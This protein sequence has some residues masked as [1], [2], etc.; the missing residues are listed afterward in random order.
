MFAATFLNIIC[1]LIANLRMDLQVAVVITEFSTSINLC[2]EDFHSQVFKF[3]DFFTMTK[4][5]NLSTSI[6]A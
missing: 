1:M 6:K 5:A 2:H 4:N 3:R